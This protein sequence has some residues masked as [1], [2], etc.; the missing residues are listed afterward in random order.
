[1]N[2]Y[3]VNGSS[4]MAFQRCRWR[5]VISWVMNR[6]PRNE[7]PAL[8]EGKLLHL[9]YE[10]VFK[11][12]RTMEE[13]I[14]FRCKEWL[15]TPTDE[16]G[17]IVAAKAVQGIADRA[18]ALVQWK[19]KYE[20]D[21]PVLEVEVPFEIEHPLDPMIHLRGR[22]D[23]VGVMQG[24]LWH[25][26]NRGLAAACNFATYIDLATRHLHEHLYAVAL[27][28]KYPQYPYGGT[29]FNLTRK[30]KYRTK[31]TKANPL[32]EVKSLDQMMLQ[33]PM[34]VDLESALHQHVMQT[35]L[36]HIYE[37][38]RVE[39]EFLGDGTMPPP[40]ESMNG[41]F[42]GSTIDPFFRVLTGKIDPM[43]DKYF[44]R[45][46]EMYGPVEEPCEG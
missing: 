45:R 15:E 32:G 27:V 44:K 17:R 40:N 7:S 2:P 22:P 9:L 31:V 43:D 10:D 1:M 28:Q 14:K 16:H 37:M 38:R 18:E 46:E 30:V 41:G 19:D 4:I 23:R 33:Y 39:A 24:S 36:A 21:I 3:I 35:A 29:L 8:A 34:V 26:Q 13:A 25:V 11:G 20:W 42:N 6:V 5:W 12:T